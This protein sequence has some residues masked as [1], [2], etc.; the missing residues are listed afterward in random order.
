MKMAPGTGRIRVLSVIDGLGFAGDESRLLSMSQALD[1]DRFEHSVLT[2]NRFAYTRPDEFEARSR[3]Y[4]AA[5][6]ELKDL[7]D[8]DPGQTSNRHSVRAKLHAKTGIPRRVLR[9]SHAIREWKVDVIDARL[10]SAGL[11]STLAGQITRTPVAITI[12]CGQWVAGDSF[13]PW[14]TRIALRLADTVITDSRVRA[15]EMKALL[16]KRPQKVTVIPNGLLPPGSDR[17]S[18]EMREVLGLPQDPRIRIIG[19]IGRLIEYKG[20]T[21]FLKAARKILNDEPDTAFLIVGYTRNEEY[22][23]GLKNLAEELGIAHRVVITD[24]RGTIGDIWAV[25]DIHAHASLFDSLPISIAEGMSLGKPA[26]VTAAGGIPEIVS[27]QQTGLVVPA[28]D[29]DAL[30][31]AVVDLLRQPALAHN[32]GQNARKRY[33]EFYTPEVMARA[34]E[35]CFLGMLRRGKGARTRF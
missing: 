35:N 31:S 32:L 7:S 30:A 10:E 12:Y 28:G 33:E 8:P 20:H 5:G 2:L 9:L 17:T 3:Q 24:Y 16:R 27:H 1:R 22:K 4:R 18:S 14:T 15:D 25:I 34:M 26:V 29:A 21:V 23:A 11:V 13:W 19:Q 6:V